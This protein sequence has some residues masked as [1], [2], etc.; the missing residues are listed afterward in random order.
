MKL[1]LTNLYSNYYSPFIKEKY[2]QDEAIF[3]TLFQK[4]W[5]IFF[6]LLLVFVPPFLSDYYVFF[7]SLV[8]IAII[9]CHGLNLLLGYTGLISLGH[10]AFVGIGGYTYSF[11]AMVLNW[12]F[13]LAIPAAGLAAGL[14]GLVIGVPSLRIKGIYLAIATVAFQFICDYTYFHFTAFSGGPQGR[15]VEAPK[16]FG[17]ALTSKISFYYICLVLLFLLLWGARN[18]MRSK[19]GR[20]LMAVRDNDISAEAI[21]I[22]VFK[23]KLLAFSLSSFYAGVAGALFVI[24]MRNVYPTFFHLSK[25]IEFVAMVIVG[26]MG[27]INGS[28]FGAIFIVLVPELLNNI[29]RI[30]AY[31]TNSPDMTVIMAPMRMMVYGLLIMIFIMVEPAGIAGIWRKFSNYFKIWPLPYV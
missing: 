18:L 22:P 6:T 27:S 26:G 15:V 13:W 28:I 24:H 3:R 2:I 5:F 12:P 7:L 10:A 29:V 25:S 9:G 23:Y 17:F 21:G 31:L 4:S 14:L 11:L 30:I 8:F 19:Y 1:S 16:L 20:C